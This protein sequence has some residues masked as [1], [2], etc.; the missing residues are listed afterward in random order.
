MKHDL[1]ITE[2]LDTVLRHLRL[3]NRVRILWIDVICINQSER[4]QQVQTMGFIYSRAHK[5]VIWLSPDKGHGYH[6]LLLH[7]NKLTIPNSDASFVRLI[8]EMC[9]LGNSP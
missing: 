1:I 4:M 8:R 3:P 5:V 9:Q 2:N 7:M 6:N